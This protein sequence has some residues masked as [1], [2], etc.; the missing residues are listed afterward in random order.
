MKDNITISKLGHL[1]MTEVRDLTIEK[2]EDIAKGKIKS[3]VGIELNK[4]LILFNDE[5]KQ[6]ISSLIKYSIDETL[7]NFLHMI[8]QNDDVDILVDKENVKTISDGLCGE[9]YSEDGWVNRY[10]NYK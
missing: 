1:L 2:Y 7:H 9:L 4:K 3:Q 8:E 6:I 10:S 5:Q